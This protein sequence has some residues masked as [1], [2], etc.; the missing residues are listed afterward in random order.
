M[1]WHR[2]STDT[3]WKAAPIILE[4]RGVPGRRIEAVI[5]GDTQPSRSDEPAL[6]RADK[7]IVVAP[8][9]QGDSLGSVEAMESEDVA[10]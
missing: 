9:Q 7:F 10:P 4:R 2:R 8:P 3:G 5:I 6:I 1:A